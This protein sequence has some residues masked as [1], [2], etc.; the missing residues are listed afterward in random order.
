[1]SWP[2]TLDELKSDMGIDLL[3]LR[4]DEQLQQ[5][6]DAA[7]QYVQRQ[8]RRSFNF[9]DPLSDLPDVTA[10]VRLGTLR[11]ARRWHTRR[12][13]PDA[14]IDM[15]ELG[16]SRVPSFDPD[17]EALLGIGRHGRPVFG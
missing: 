12:R 10:D 8:R 7:V 6:L 1:M 5:V 9:G 16:V 4:D 3:D 13:S 14:L 11:L 17:I 15:G 2:P